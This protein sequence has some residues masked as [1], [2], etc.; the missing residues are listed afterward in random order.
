[1]GPEDHRIAGRKRSAK[2]GMLMCLCMVASRPSPFVASGY[3]S[4]EILLFDL[5]AAK[6]YAA[7]P[8]HKEPVL[9][10][11]VDAAG[12]KMISGAADKNLQVASIAPGAAVAVT[13][14]IALPKPGAQAISLR[15]DQRIVAVA[16]W[17]RRVR[18]FAWG[19]MRPLAILKHHTDGVT[20][21]SWSCDGRTLA[22]ASKDGNLGLWNLHRFS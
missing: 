21:L 16:G 17:D 15:H 7:A 9:S 22:S 13:Q 5:K 4:G 10:V 8:A 20:A 11:E 18:L 19:T 1:M 14:T 12:T 2:T 3:E 6:A